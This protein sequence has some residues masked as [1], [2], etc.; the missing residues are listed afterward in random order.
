MSILRRIII[1]VFVMLITGLPISVFFIQGQLSL[2]TPVYAVRIG[3]IFFCGGT[4]LAML[5]NLIFTDSIRKYL[6][7]EKCF[8][9]PVKSRKKSQLATYR[10]EPMELNKKLFF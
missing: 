6:S 1:P 4:S 9:L 7:S 10:L 2:Q 8:L 3:M 5:M